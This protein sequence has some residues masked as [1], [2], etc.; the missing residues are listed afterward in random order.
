MLRRMAEMTKMKLDRTLYD[1]LLTWTEALE[2]M[3]EH[4]IGRA[5]KGTWEKRA[6]QTGFPIHRPNGPKGTRYVV[7]SEV[8][9]FL[10]SR[11]IASRPDQDV[12]P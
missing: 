1:S 5:S 10:R 7:P 6:R 2:F 8:D 4:S 3:N 11:C 12:A 9:A